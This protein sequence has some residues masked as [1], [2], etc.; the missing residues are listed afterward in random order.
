MNFKIS[1][2][3]HYTSSRELNVDEILKT[4]GTSLA[5]IKKTMTDAVFVYRNLTEGFQKELAKQL[6]TAIEKHFQEV[7]EQLYYGGRYSPTMRETPDVAV[8]LKEHSKKIFIEIEFHPSEYKDIVKFLIG[9][10]MQTLELA[11]L[12]VP[13]DRKTITKY[14]PGRYGT[15]TEFRKCVQIV[16]ELQPDCPIWIMGFEGKWDIVEEN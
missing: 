4:Y 8:G 10:K 1:N 12:I 6:K 14:S 13:I 2:V 9:Y 7:R 15:M 5:N 11:I 3:E 16:K